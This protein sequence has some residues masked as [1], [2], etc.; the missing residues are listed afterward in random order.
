M[1]LPSDADIKAKAAEL[2]L[3]DG[4]GEVPQQQRGRIAKLLME[5]PGPTETESAP[6]LLSRSI[7]RVDG[8]FITVD[9]H[10]HTGDTA[11]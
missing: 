5:I 4:D 11:P 10:L 7:T 6:I 3:L 2:G 9:V 1:R 8:G